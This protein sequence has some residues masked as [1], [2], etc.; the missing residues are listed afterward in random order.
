MDYRIRGFIYSIKI[1]LITASTDLTRNDLG[2]RNEKIDILTRSSSL[3]TGSDKTEERSH[4][5]SRRRRGEI[6]QRGGMNGVTQHSCTFR[7]LDKYR[8]S[9]ILFLRFRW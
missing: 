2:V 5:P 7:A 6:G 4:F 9:M 1:Y 8:I 3:N